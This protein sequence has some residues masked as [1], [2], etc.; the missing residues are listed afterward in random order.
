MSLRLHTLPTDVPVTLAEARAHLRVDTNDEDAYIEA[1]VKAATSACENII[2]RAIMPQVWEQVLDF[3]PV[4]AIRL[5]R[6]PVSA[7]QEVAYVNEAGQ[8]VVI[9]SADFAL[10]NARLPGWC[11][12]TAGTDWPRTETLEQANSVI[13]RFSCG[14]ADAS[15]VPADLKQ[16]I[17]L[18]VGDLFQNR[19]RQIDF[20]LKTNDFADNLLNRWRVPAL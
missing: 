17:L 12:L 4:G 7:I 3:F 19:E 16:W 8:T 5:G 6:P 10:D 13:V 15:L 20:R 14:W 1:L 18:A 11:V 9:N 2:N